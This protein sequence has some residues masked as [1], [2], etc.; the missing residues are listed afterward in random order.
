MTNNYRVLCYSIVPSPYQRDLFLALS[1]HPSIQLTVCYLE[2]ASPDSPWPDRPLQPYESILPGFW[3]AWGQ[4]RFHFNWYPIDFQQ[5]DAI[6]LNGYQ[7]SIAQI[8]ARTV[9]KHIPLIFWGEQLQE[10]FGG[11][12]GWL[13]KLSSRMLQRCDAIVAI[14]SKAQADYQRRFP[15]KPVFNIP[16]YCDL[17]P[18]QQNIPDRPRNPVTILFCGQMIY[19][20]G[21]DLLLKAFEELILSGYQA[22]LLLVGREAELPQMLEAIDPKVLPSIEYAGFQPPECLPDFFDQGD[23]FVLPSRYDG[24]GVVVNQALGA[25]LPLICST[26]VG[27]AYDL[28]DPEVNGYLIPLAD[29]KNLLFKTLELYLNNPYRIKEA[30]QKSHFRSEAWTPQI[31]AKNWVSTIQTAI[32]ITKDKFVL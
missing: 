24:W 8:L 10:Q 13:Q 26:A 22:R 11:L 4:S 32:N 28:L 29:H 9:P 6:I 2:A 18:F 16:Y 23:I 5:Y 27:S 7:H 20:K 25:G 14:G 31:G 15:D 19:R 17:T 30:S 3:I 21:V 1:Q 12:K